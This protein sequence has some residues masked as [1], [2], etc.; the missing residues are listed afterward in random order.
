MNE[1]KLQKLLNDKDVT[2]LELADAVGVSQAFMS[3]V[4]RGLKEPSLTVLKRMAEYLDVTVN[5]LV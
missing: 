3:M 5:D 2:Q 1:E 4:V